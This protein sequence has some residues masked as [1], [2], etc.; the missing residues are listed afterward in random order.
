M[1]NFYKIWGSFGG[2]ADNSSLTRRYAE[3]LGKTVPDILN[4]CSVFLFRV[5]QSK[6]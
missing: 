3:L 2:T 6:N 4:S 5:Q 1:N